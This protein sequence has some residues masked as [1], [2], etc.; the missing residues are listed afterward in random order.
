MVYNSN[1]PA[2]TDD[3]SIS[4][5][6][7]QGNFAQANTTFDM[8]HYSFEDVSGDTGKHHTIT[9]PD[10]TADPATAADEPKLYANSILTTNATV[11]QF[12]RGGGNGVVVPI[13]PISTTLIGAGGAQ[14]LY[15]F[16]GLTRGIVEYYGYSDVATAF[17]ISWG[18]AFMDGN[19][20]YIARPAT[21]QIQQLTMSWSGSKLRLITILG[22]TYTFNFFV[23][24]IN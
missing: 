14:D 9:T 21:A 5:S 3:Q 10:Q 2:A 7:I 17:K 11:L 18:I 16:D 15:D 12:T 13:T 6:D 19:A 20:F 24:R 22:E 8:D 23:R 1:K 4:Q